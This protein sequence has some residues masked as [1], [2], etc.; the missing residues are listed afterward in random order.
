M[1]ESVR[2]TMSG[3]KIQFV[4]AAIAVVGMM[5]YAVPTFQPAIA[6]DSD[7]E[8]ETDQSFAQRI[9]DDTRQSIDQDQD[10]DA[11][12][13][14]DQDQSARNDADQSNTA[15]V[16][17]PETNTQS[18]VL[19]TGDNDATTS[20]SG[21][22]EADDN[23]ANAASSGGSG[24]SGKCCDDNK[25]DDWKKDHKDKCDSCSGSG[26]DS[27]AI[28]KVGI[29]QDV[30]NTATTVQDSSADNNRLTNNNEF[31]DDVAVVDQ[32]NTADQDATNIGV[33]DQDPDQDQDQDA[34]NFNFD[35]D[36]QYGFSQQADDQSANLRDINVDLP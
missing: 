7:N 3:H 4:V 12:Q 33:Q 36:L 15:S 34:D 35:F 17:Q 8:D 29:D 1:F 11:S 6:Q 13:D 19:A 18:N 23:D 28:A 24:G 22:N 26:G 25:H 9:I 30:D 20:Q 16:S 21:S 27:K 32:D 31:G 5:I 14:Q 2:R 10:Q